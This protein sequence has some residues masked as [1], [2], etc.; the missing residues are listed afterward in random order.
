VNPGDMILYTF[1]SFTSSSRWKTEVG[2]ILEELHGISKDTKFYRIL[3]SSG[4]Q[5]TVAGSSIKPL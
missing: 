3:R 5:T 4:K 1:N 2:L